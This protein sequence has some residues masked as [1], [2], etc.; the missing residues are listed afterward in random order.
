MQISWL[1]S[2]FQLMYLQNL[3]FSFYFLVWYWQ[4]TFTISLIFWDRALGD[5][6]WGLHLDYVVDGN[7]K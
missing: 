2:Y 1:F 7:N 4:M 5:H 3:D 6:M